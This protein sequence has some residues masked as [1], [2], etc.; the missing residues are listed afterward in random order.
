MKRLSFLLFIAMFAQNTWAQKIVF[1]DLNLKAALLE[2]GYDRNKDGEIEIT[3]IDTVTKLD[4][5]EKKI[6]SLDDLKYFKSL[7]VIAASSNQI[8]NLDVFFDND[9]VEGIYV[10]GNPL[11]KRLTLK[12]IK[13]LKILVAFRSGLESIDLSG[14]NHIEL[15]YL[16]GNDLKYIAFPDLANL[17]GLTLTGNKNLKSI[18]ISSNPKLNYLVLLDTSLSKLDITKNPMLLTLYVDGNVQLIKGKN[19][20]NLKPAPV[21]KV[22]N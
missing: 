6:R 2:K 9:V 8:E 12:N 20:S 10:G 7:K 15:L 22:S 21:F 4:V 1:K 17:Q 13:N 11:G 16:Q 18:D 14:T 19:Q 5:S 3:E